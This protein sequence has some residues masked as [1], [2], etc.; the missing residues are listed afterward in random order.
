MNLHKKIK[1]CH[2]NGITIYP[3]PVENSKGVRN[4]KCYITVNN[5]GE[6]KK[7]DYIYTQN[8]KMYVEIERI[9]SKIYDKNN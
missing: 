2:N 1:W 3:V 5:N 6:E 7:K 8:E 9:Y 4:P